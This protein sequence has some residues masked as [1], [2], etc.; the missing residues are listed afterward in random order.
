MHFDAIDHPRFW[1]PVWPLSA[2]FLLGLA[3]H[4]RTLWAKGSAALIVT[5][6]FGM[7]CAY[8]LTIR[9]DL[10]LAHRTTGLLAEP[11]QLASSVLPEAAQCRLFVMDARPFMLNRELGPTSD[12]PL[13]SEELESAA[14]EHE[15]VCL[16]VVHKR[17]RLSTTA[18]RRRPLQAAVV[19][20]LVA[21]GRLER[22]AKAAGVTVFRL[23]HETAR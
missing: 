20:A 7:L 8:G 6:M 2:L 16:A 23:T 17:L 1:V 15:T 4:A 21:Q 19:D 18:E 5:A 13:S 9:R 3:V 22:L 11:W 14:R 10:P 12:I